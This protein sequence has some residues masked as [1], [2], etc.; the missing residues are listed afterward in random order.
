[1]LARGQHGY[2]KA[3]QSSLSDRGVNLMKKHLI[4]AASAALVLAGAAH[5]SGDHHHASWSYGGETGPEAWGKLKSE[6]SACTGNQQSPINIVAK[7]ALESDM[8]KIKFD[9][10]DTALQV[11]NNGHTIQANYDEGSSIK[12]NGD[13]FDLLQFHF[14]SPSEHALNGE[15][16]D[17]EAHFVH[18]ADNGELAV[19][20]VFFKEGKENKALAPIWNNMPQHVETKD[21]AGI[22]INGEDLLPKDTKEYFHYMGSLTTPPCSEVVNWY[23]LAEPIE[24]SKEQIEAFSEV[25]HANNRPVQPLNRR[26]VLAN[27]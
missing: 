1:M 23:V 9:W 27:D 16:Y 2:P 11:K 14:H 20:G 3:F 12:V 18:K 21:V 17:M 24:A 26:F 25:I 10:S 4:A 6:Y 13:K 7:Q 22:K 15:L 19:V 5:A 8:T